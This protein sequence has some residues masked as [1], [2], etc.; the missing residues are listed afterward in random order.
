M[1]R[2]SF[3]LGTSV[4]RW[5]PL[6]LAVLVAA[7]SGL[8]TAIASEPFYAWTGAIAVL[9]LILVDLH[10][11]THRANIVSGSRV[12]AQLS[13]LDAHLAE[14][15]TAI[16]GL[17]EFSRSDA[18]KDPWDATSVERVLRRLG[19]DPRGIE[20]RL[21]RSTAA[22]VSALLALHSLVTNSI[23]IPPPGGWAATPETLL[24]L[25]SAV[26][27]LPVGATVVECGSGTSTVW[28][29]IVAQLR[30]GDVTIISLEHEESFA[31]QTRAALSRAGMLAFADV[32][33][34][35]LEQY[36]VGDT[37]YEWYSP[38]AYALI[39]SID[40]LFVDGPPG[41][42]GPT[43]RFP[44]YPLLRDRLTDGATVILDD[45]NRSDERKILDRWQQLDGEGRLGLER[46]LD[47]SSVL[48]FS[49]QADVHPG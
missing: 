22:D 1:V 21:H 20:E 7:A 47:R 9:V 11:R 39:D 31:A 26:R 4:T 10:V 38:E 13:E 34:A 44:A 16:E 14:V 48:R 5:I 35:P 12:D 27:A 15:V 45:T 46:E 19:S 28:L 25:V 40:V 32:R 30:G 41:K 8:M 37:Q 29:G 43:A 6:A 24:A 3:D 18:A 49:R 33:L 23:E 42:T 36:L 2:R 17:I